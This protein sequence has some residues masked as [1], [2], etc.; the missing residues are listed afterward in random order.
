[1]IWFTWRQ[2]RTQ[3]F[4]GAVLVAFTAV[5]FVLYGQSIRAAYTQDGIGACL[6]GGTG[7]DH[8][9]SVLSAFVDQFNGVSNHLLTWFSPVPGLIG[10]VV[11]A[12]VLG[13]EYEHGTWR[14]AWTQAVPRTRWLTIK[15]LLISIG[16]TVVTASLSAIFGWFRSPMDQV[17]GRFAPGAFDLEGLSLTGYALFA[18][19]LGVLA[20]LLLRRT[21]PAIV[22]AFV[23][24]MAVRLPVEFWLRQRYQSPITHLV[25]P[26]ANM[27]IG[28]KSI[29]TSPGAPGW[30]LSAHDLVFKTGKAPSLSMQNQI[31]QKLDSFRSDAAASAYLRGLGLYRKVVYQPANRFWTFQIIEAALF[32]GLATALLS[33]TIWHLHHRST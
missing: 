33:I 11:G 12:G 14:L 24:F 5:V 7:G 10:A 27:T 29:P 6:A 1:M 4:A 13:R 8:C 9:Q 25:D 23:A 20:G 21:V 16:I 17:T 19:A 31:Y 18:F 30:I 3:A 28:P 32:I 26:T 15:I 2:H 22:T